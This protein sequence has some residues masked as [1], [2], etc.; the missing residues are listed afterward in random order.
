MCPGT[1]GR[2]EVAAA[3]QAC[4]PSGLSFKV[5]ERVRDLVLFNLAIDSKLRGCDVTSLKVDDVARQVA[6]QL[7]V[8]PS[9]RSAEVD[10]P[11]CKIRAI[12]SHETSS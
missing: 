12:G 6:I 2:S 1:N 7:T 5:E 4:G 11:P 10:R 8:L 3:A 9:G